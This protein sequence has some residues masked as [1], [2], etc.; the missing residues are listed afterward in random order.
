MDLVSARSRVRHGWYADGS[1]LI[2]SAPWTGPLG[3]F[4]DLAGIGSLRG[5]H[6]IQNALAAS[7]AALSLGV[8]PADVAAALATFPGLP[9]RLEEIG[10]VGRTLYINDS[11]A[12]NADSAATALAAFDRDVLWILGG[13]PKQ[14]GIASLTSFFPRVAKAYLIGEA[15]EEFAATL[16]GKVPFA[17]LRHA[18]P[19][20]GRGFRR[21]R[22]QRRA[23]AGRAALA[24][25][26]LVRP[27]PQLRGARRGVPRP[28]RG[29]AGDRAARARGVMRIALCPSAATGI[30]APP[31][32]EGSV[33]GEGQRS[34]QRPR[35]FVQILA[36]TLALSPQAG[37]GVGPRLALRMAR[38]SAMTLSRA[39]KSIVTDWWF[40]VDRMLLATILTIAGAGV[41][42]SLAAS[43]AIAI[44]RGLPTYYFVER[45]LVFIAL[46][47]AIMLGLSLLSPER[48]RR[49]ALAHSRRASCSSLAVLAGGAEINGA[50]RWVHIGGYSLQPSEFAKPA[51]VVLCAWLLA[52]GPAPAGHAGA[53]RGVR[54]LP[55]CS[56]ASWP[57][58]PTSA[59]RCSSALVWCALFFLAGGRVAWFLAF[60]GDAGARPSATAY[61]TVGYVRLRVDR[62]LSPGAGDSYQAG[63]ARQ[64]FIEGGLF[65][66]GPGEGTIKA[67][68]PDAHN[69]FIFAVIAEEY[70]V[71]VCLVLLGLFALVV[72]RV[73]ARQMREG[74]DFL[75]L[76]AMGLALLFGLQ[77]IINMAVNTGLLPTKGMTLPFISIGGSS[78][79]A[80][81]VGLGMLLRLTPAPAPT[82]PT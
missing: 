6:N 51:F 69:D 59:R 53:A 73:F 5:Q 42:L 82:S 67:V 63:R 74:D 79:L 33:R 60:L 27:L 68:L 7:A 64:S 24:R 55:R 18:R 1:T 30:P 61:S 34:K 75:R 31:W 10:R 52:R 66:R 43:P 9:H 12:T 16:D 28:G 37:R 71:L 77:A 78:T 23:R 2:S 54:P 40:T 4:A 21:C 46:A 56:P 19:C 48:I 62:F 44:K 81:G 20:R 17:A 76:A 72:A 11:K 58:S 29:A 25:L 49:L 13:R 35:A 39:E 22:G 47:V 26:R 41:V 8:P 15:T 65:G 36:L 70:G 57:C 32:G 3:A 38:W 14:G 50:R 45:Q 80:A